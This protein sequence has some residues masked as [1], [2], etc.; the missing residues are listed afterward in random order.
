M[1]PRTLLRIIPAAL[2][3]ILLAAFAAEFYALLTLRIH[4][5]EDQMARLDRALIHRQTIVRT[6]QSERNDLAARLAQSETARRE[7]ET[8]TDPSLHDRLRTE[9]ARLSEINLRLEAEREAVREETAR[10]RNLLSQAETL[11]LQTQTALN[12]TSNEIIRLRQ[13][14]QSL[15]DR[16]AA[17]EREREAART[18]TAQIRADLAQ[19]QETIRTLERRRND[20][21]QKRLLSES[22][23]ATL[24]K[25]LAELEA[26]LHA[27]RNPTPTPTP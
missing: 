2:A 21:E 13:S 17:A 8:K 9:I 24:E 15:R 1:P 14:E 20:E 4:T 16:L 25:R 3:V 7:L 18:E 23:T 22:R 26:Q 27:L 19:A 5:A 11:Q 6:L 12:T 10:L